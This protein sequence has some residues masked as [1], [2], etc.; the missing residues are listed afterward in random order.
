M[1]SWRELKRFCERD[2]WDYIRI[3]TITII[4]KTMR[5]ARQDLP[6]SPKGLGRF[7]KGYGKIY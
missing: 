7:I 6:K 1:P 4:E 3:R 2:G 5:M